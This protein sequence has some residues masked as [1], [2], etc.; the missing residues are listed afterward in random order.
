MGLGKKEPGNAV[1]VLTS[2]VIVVVFVS[3]SPS[4][5]LNH[6]N[7][8]QTGVSPSV[9]LSSINVSHESY[10]NRNVWNYLN[11]ESQANGSSP[12]YKLDSAFINWYVKNVNTLPIN[13]RNLSQQNI[14]SIF[15][16][17]VLETGNAKIMIQNA[18]GNEPDSNATMV[19]NTNGPSDPWVTETL[20]VI[21]TTILFWQVPWEYK[22]ASFLKFTNQRNAADFEN[23]L[24]S[25]LNG[26]AAFDDVMTGFIFTL[27]GAGASVV[28]GIITGL[29]GE[30]WGDLSGTT[31]PGSI[32]H[33]VAT[34]YG[35]QV[36]SYP[37]NHYYFEVVYELDNYPLIATQGYSVYGPI[38]GGS[39]NLFGTL[40]PLNIF[41][42]TQMTQ[43][44]DA[45]DN[46]G[47]TYGLNNW[48]YF[49]AP[50]SWTTFF[51]Y[52]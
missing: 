5:A 16:T 33:N 8:M 40:N 2:S 11:A 50:P 41:G 48:V 7:Q 51:G 24:M 21:Y 28:V 22:Y 9:S 6:L 38:V 10:I 20:N 42:S 37:T 46:F 14:S 12:Q 44:I 19:T 18:L 52:D 35:N 4:G 43:Y 25:A 31:Q 47:N 3:S 29:I 30:L 45:F 36:A 26:A 49:G 27:L 1:V 39:I 13:S 32:A 23:F 17:F 15:G 34:L